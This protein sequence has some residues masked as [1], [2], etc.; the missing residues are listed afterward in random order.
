[1]AG[2]IV[3]TAASSGT[4]TLTPADTGN[5][6]VVTVP[7]ETGNVITTGSTGRV[8]PKAAMP[9]G[10]I[11]Q[12]VQTVKT[13]TYSFSSS[14]YTAV[15]GMTVSI[16]PTSASNQILVLLNSYWAE[17]GLDCTC[18]RLKRNST[19]IFV[20]DAAGTRPQA[21]GASDYTANN[22]NFIGA[23]YLDSP[24]TTSAITYSIDASVASGTSYLNRTSADA[25]NIYH[26]RTASSITVMEI[27]V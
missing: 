27:A 6:F 21:S 26:P 22:L 18:V 14:S 7:A 16:T 1:M 4:V 23:T 17:S 12:V 3:L 19:V 25:D 10:T 13:N 5:A 9:A 24:N 2:Q 8:I 11:L 20:G 15:T